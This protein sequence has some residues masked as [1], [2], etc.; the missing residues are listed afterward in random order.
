MTEQVDMSEFRPPQF[1]GTAI[2]RPVY[3][4]E[5]GDRP[6]IVL[7]ELPGMSPSFIQYCRDMVGEGFK[8]YMPLI[9]KSPGTDMGKM[10]TVAFCLS[11]EFRDLFS[12]EGG[13]NARPF[14]AW[15]LELVQEVSDNHPDENVGVIGMCLTGGFAIAAIAE[16]QVQAVA[17]CQPSAPF[18]FNIET[19][20]LSETERQNV[21]ASKAE[22]AIP[23]V[24]AYRYQKDSICRES[25]MTAAKTLL[26]PSMERFPDLP[27]KG[28]ST[29]TSDTRDE[30]VYQDVLAFLNQRL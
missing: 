18:I 20:G 29:L 17:A 3:V 25:H 24:K 6:L 13:S 5:T 15:L 10:A 26:G 7:H 14:T 9:F 22:K 12:A 27:G 1:M 28:H 21:K 30:G 8:V 2:Q 19:L 16:P 23:C 11:R 4:S